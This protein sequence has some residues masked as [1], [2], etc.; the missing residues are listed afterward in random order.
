MTAGKKGRALLEV[1][2]LAQHFG[3]LKAVDQ[4]N[5]TVSEGEIVS[6]IGPNGA[7]KTTFFNVLTGVYPGT[8][9]QILFDGSPI[10]GLPS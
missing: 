5:M 8:R 1:K 4:V 10:R 7:G 6:V 3:G 2:D 9:G